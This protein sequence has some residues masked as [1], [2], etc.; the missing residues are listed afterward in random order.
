MYMV[1]IIIALKKLDCRDFSLP[2]KVSESGSLFQSLCHRSLTVE[3]PQLPINR[4]CHQLKKDKSKINIS[5]IL[6]RNIKTSV[7]RINS[8]YQHILCIH[9][10]ISTGV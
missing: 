5:L 6:K 2:V 4:G 8:D 9:P 7:A 10:A 1:R 3:Q